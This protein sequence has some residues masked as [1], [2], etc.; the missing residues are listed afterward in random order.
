ML[1]EIEYKTQKIKKLEESQQNMQLQLES[2]MIQL[3]KLND[4]KEELRKI[5]VENDRHPEILTLRGEITTLLMD[6]AK[7]LQ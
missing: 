3:K 4:E 1:K 2:Y 5:Y 7:L 6:K